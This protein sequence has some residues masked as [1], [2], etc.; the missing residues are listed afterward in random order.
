MGQG[1]DGAAAA[2]SAGVTPIVSL[3]LGYALFALGLCMALAIFIL[4]RPGMR[5][6]ADANAPLALGNGLLSLALA[7][8][9]QSYF[10]VE[11]AARRGPSIDM[12]RVMDDPIL[13]RGAFLYFSE[14]MAGAP[15][16]LWSLGNEPTDAVLGLSL[17]SRRIGRSSRARSTICVARPASRWFRAS[18]S[19][20]GG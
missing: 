15:P 4:T 12:T 1:L 5:A 10:R 7:R 17:R 8:D 18:R 6:K 3:L 19:P 11:L 13:P 2:Q 9:G 14:E 20:S 16:R